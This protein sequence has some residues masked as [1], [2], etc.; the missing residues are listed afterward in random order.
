M[1]GTGVVLGPPLI[2]DGFAEEV[3]NRAQT[4]L[5]SDH[6][7]H[8]DRSKGRQQIFMSLETK[9]LLLQHGDSALPFRTN[10]HAVP[11][12]KTMDLGD[13]FQMELVPS[14]H[15]LGSSQVVLE[16]PDGYR[17]GY[18]GDFDY[19]LDNVITVDELV[20][21][22]TYGGFRSNREFSQSEA[23][24]SLKDLF[25]SRIAHGPVLF[26]GHRGVVPPAL[27]ALSDTMPLPVVATPEHALDFAVYERNGFTLPEWREVSSSK[28]EE[29]FSLGH[30]V[31]VASLG[32]RC[33]PNSQEV[34]IISL[35]RDWTQREPV[36]RVGDRAWHV[37]LS[38]HADLQG[39]LAYIRDTGAS[40]VLTDNVR[41]SSHG[42]ELAQTVRAQLGIEAVAC[43]TVQSDAWGMGS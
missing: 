13:G 23:L 6:M 24:E 7:E 18:S 22:S 29:S 20:V 9:E 21:D 31:V 34:S 8:F 2:C 16:Y 25:C 40:V 38:S 1:I 33:I 27:E 19:P 36:L 14:G 28:V 10:L 11:A 35:R 12:G 41:G 5:H 15:M 17:V 43:P 42:I 4:H 39:T 37:G 3:P 32:N 30:R 26:K